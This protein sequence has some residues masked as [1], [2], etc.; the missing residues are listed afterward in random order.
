MPNTTPQYTLVM[1][2]SNPNCFA[3][4]LDAENEWLAHQSTEG[5]AL[6]TIFKQVEH[7]LSKSDIH[8][9]QIERFLYCGGPGSTLGLR[10]AAMAIRTWR[11]LHKTPPPCYAYN[12]LQLAGNCLLLDEPDLAD[13]L[14]VA[15]WKK[16]LWNALVLQKNKPLECTPIDENFLEN[17]EGPSFHLPQRKGWQA[18]PPN[19]RTLIYQPERLNSVIDTP[20]FLKAVDTPTPFVGAASNFQKWTPDR[21]RAPNSHA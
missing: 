20:G 5:V 2:A 4:I 7:V 15:D 16:G 6:E 8:L 3:G 14:L 11:A 19:A 9:P 12:S 13:A 17:W 21:H 18:P 10:L 1:D